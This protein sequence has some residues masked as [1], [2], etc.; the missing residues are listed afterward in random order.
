MSR[1]IVPPG[2][3]AQMA[4][5]PDLTIRGRIATRIDELRLAKCS[6]CGADVI[7]P[8]PAAGPLVGMDLPPI[9]R[10]CVKA[11]VDRGD[12]V[13]AAAPFADRRA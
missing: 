7:E 11:A 5:T 4:A 10:P 9:C 1:P 13:L 12:D 6:A 2:I 8:P 3:L